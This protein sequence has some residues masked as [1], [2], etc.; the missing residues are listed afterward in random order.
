MKRE[1]ASRN[2]SNLLTLKQEH[3]ELWKGL[4]DNPEL[5]RVLKEDVEVASEP[6]NFVEEIFLHQVIVHA[7]VT[8]ELLEAGTPVDKSGFKK[9][10][11]DFFR[12]PLPRASWLGVRDAHRKEFVS[13]LEGAVR[14]AEA[15]AKRKRK[16]DG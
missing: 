15:K 2:L 13:F 8:Y 11:G 10:V 7:A 3:R 14:T 5:A 4:H 6:L 9:D 12:R 16:N 1:K